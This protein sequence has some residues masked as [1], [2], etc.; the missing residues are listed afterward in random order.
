[1][2]LPFL[3]WRDEWR[4]PGALRADALAGLTGAI[5]VLPQGVAFA[6]LAGLPP[7][8]GLWA[9][10]LPC[11]VA[12]LF[13]SSRLMVT[14]PANAISLSTLALL[15]PLATPF[16]AR[17]VELAITLAFLVGMMQVLQAVREFRSS[18]DTTPVVLM[19]YANPVE[20]YNLAHG[21]DRFVQDAAAAGVDCFVAGS[22]V[23]GAGDPAAAVE[24][25]RRQAGAASPHL[26]V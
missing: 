4:Q 16:S 12:A 2:N 26:R 23:Y 25:L 14:G 15:A 9:A 11:V 5:V 22:A 24:A 1:M 20:A 21:P 3:R 13:G 10:M 6:T 17:Y 18:N 19:G 7:Q 8:H